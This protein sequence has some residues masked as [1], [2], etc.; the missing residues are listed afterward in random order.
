MHTSRLI[1]AATIAAVMLSGCSTRPRNFSAELAAPVPDRAAFANDYRTCQQLVAAG[2]R[3]D[4]KVKAV[5]ATAGTAGA[6]GTGAILAPATMTIGAGGGAGMAAAAVAMPV[7]GVLAAFGISR[8]IRG[9]KEKKQRQAMSDCLAEYGYTVDGWNKL[10]KREDAAQA[11][12][13][14]AMVEGEQT[15]SVN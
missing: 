12:A 1:C 13:D 10:G 2:H 8:A 15:A 6:L 7:V 4:F 9:G 5:A 11:A 3:S 14:A